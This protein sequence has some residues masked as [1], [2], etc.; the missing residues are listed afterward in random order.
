MALFYAYMAAYEKPTLLFRFLLLTSLLAMC[1][2]AKAQYSPVVKPATSVAE[3]PTGQPCGFTLP[4]NHTEQQK[5]LQL[6]NKLLQRQ[7]NAQKTQDNNTAYKLPV[8]FHIVHNNGPENISEAAVINTLALLNDAFANTNAFATTGGVDTKISFCMGKNV[9]NG[10]TVTGITRHASALTN[11]TMETDDA[12]LKQ[13]GAWNATKY[14][15]IWVV[16]AINSNVNGPGVAGYAYLPSA[17]GADYD[18][19]VIE[20]ALLDG[21]KNNAKVLIHE[22]GH[23]L[24]LYH[25]FE[26]GCK[27]DDCQQDGDKVCDTPPDASTATSANCTNGINSCF[28]DTDDHS[29]NN[30]FRP[31]ALGGLGDQP[32]MLINYMDY[33]GLDCPDRFTPGQKA[34]MRNAV[35]VARNSL[36]ADNTL[37]SGCLIAANTTIHVADTIDAGIPVTYTVMQPPASSLLLLWTIDGQS[38]S[39]VPAP[40]VTITKQHDFDA[41]VSLIDPQNG[42]FITASKS[43]YAKCSY[44]NPTFTVNPSTSLDNP[45]DVL[46]FQS[47]GP[48]TSYVWRVDGV[49]LSNSS[50]FTYTIPDNLSRLVTLEAGNGTCSVETKPYLIQP[51]NCREAGKENN[52]WY[53]GYGAGL[54]FGN[55]QVTGIHTPLPIFPVNAIA[56]GPDVAL[57]GSSVVSDANGTPLYYSI[58]NKVNSCET[59]D[60]LQNGSDLFG[61]V[62]TTQSCLFVP[63]PNDDRYI[64]LF[65]PDWQ[66]GEVKG[67]TFFATHEGGLYYSV[68]DKQGDNGKG[69]VIQKNILLAKPVTEKVIAIKNQAGNGIWVIAHAW[70][71][72]AFMAWLVNDTGVMATPVISN[73]GLIHQKTADPAD[74]SG[75]NAI[76]EMKATTAGDKIAVALYSQSVLQTF[77]FDNASGIVSNPITLQH[78]DVKQPY[79]VSYSPNGRFLYTSTTTI[80]YMLVRWDL[81]NTTETAINQSLQKVD[82]GRMYMLGSVQQGPDGMIYI[83]EV[84][85]N[86]LSVLTNPNAVNVKNCNLN[87]SGLKLA[88]TSRVQYGLQNLVQTTLFSFTPY[89]YGSAKLC[90]KPGQDTTL[91]YSFSKAGNG[92]YTWQLKGKNALL[93]ITD[94]TASVHFTHTGTDTLILKRSAPCNDLYDTLVIETKSPQYLDILKDTTICKGDTINMQAPFGYVDY[95]WNY[96]EYPFEYHASQKQIWQKG[97]Q[98]VQLTNEY[99][100]TFRDSAYV[101]FK[102]LPA[103][104]NIG[105]DT[106]ICTGSTLTLQGPAGMD[107]YQWSNG[108]TTPSITISN[109]GVYKLSV[110]SEGCL[111]SDSMKVWKDVPA[112]LIAFDTLASC[113]NSNNGDSLLKAPQGFTNY[114][115][116]R[117]DGSFVNTDSIRVTTSGYYR[118]QYTNNCG[119]AR[120]SV[121]F[122]TPQLVDQSFYITCNDSITLNSYYPMLGVL[123]DV[124]NPNIIF[125]PNTSTATIKDKGNYYLIASIY[126][127]PSWANS[128]FIA[129]RITVK[130]DTAYT[131]PA[132]QINLG[133]DTSFCTNGVMPLRVGPGFKNCVWNTGERQPSITAYNF[134]TYYVTAN[135]CSYA[136]SDTIH[137]T[138]KTTGCQSV[139]PVT[140]L[141]FTARL[142][143]AKTVFLQWQTTNQINSAY[144]MVE[145]SINGS[146]FLPVATV[147][148]KGNSGNMQSYAFTD[149]LYNLPPNLHTVYYR[150]KPVDQNGSYTYSET[151]PV[152]LA[153]PQEIFTLYPNP[154]KGFFVL[155]TSQADADL[156]VYDISGRI[157]LKQAISTSG[158][159][160]ISTHAWPKGTYM[161]TLRTAQKVQTQKVVIE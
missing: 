94:T 148:A 58:G 159:H 22:L 55:S 74:S 7:R 118:L 128:C 124:P 137:I 89:I 121:Y 130:L 141:S 29:N 69:A 93:N 127:V 44:N 133:N 53:F 125:T 84:G 136:Y 20:A 119:T 42:C 39:F 152:N 149:T 28:T 95:S 150:I 27:N 103:P 145:R 87:R 32:D 16:N 21:T 117:P 34:R 12:A 76:G 49:Q 43:I 56:I 3:T 111:Y 51:G 107:T 96:N 2:V 72:D 54:H 100:C 48:A 80:P 23:Y 81:Q 154:A 17:H 19:I 37:C 122:F 50:S 26:G 142:Q 153:A 14:I 92:V 11:M 120:D 105:N 36:L 4:R 88:D 115:W 75:A 146:N 97:W 144:F 60:V 86:F 161:I 99:G 129:Q 33:S 160:N 8:V 67:A 61:S 73:V 98:W 110:T 38:F 79:G 158:Q 6:E 77:N 139:V 106:S 112:N 24:G 66:A 151:R 52:T 70:N 10:N 104:L 57:E 15:N 40:T 101:F 9:V 123:A 147:T 47:A 63:K 135:Y 45:G 85:R 62:T 132:A 109:E 65:T 31:V 78:A 156:T 68:I 90:L 131:K 102:T 41:S 1:L 13:L 113:S 157:I 155:Y 134:G 126:R 46:T 59:G 83:A 5:L 108:P 114:Q 30:P 35:A 71:S 140:L 18:G 64:Y 116:T 82:S 91:T 25:T 138:Q 143:T